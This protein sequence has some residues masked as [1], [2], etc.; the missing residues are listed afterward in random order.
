MGSIAAAVLFFALGLLGI[1]A[2]LSPLWT[3][4]PN[5]W[6][7]IRDYACVEV[8]E[9]PAA[10]IERTG[11]TTWTENQDNGTVWVTTPDGRRFEF[12]RFRSTCERFARARRILT[13]GEPIQPPERFR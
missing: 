11:A 8:N 7:Q 1:A 10:L 2:H 12:W 13:S 6:F 4:P 5:P 3:T 9:S